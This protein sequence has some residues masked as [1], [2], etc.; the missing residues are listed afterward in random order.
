MALWQSQNRGFSI[1]EP[2][3]KLHALAGAPAG[4]LKPVP[5]LEKGECCVAL[6]KTFSALGGPRVLISI[7]A[8]SRTW[9]VIIVLGI[10][11]QWSI[12]QVLHQ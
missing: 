1:L 8:F 5:F 12:M 6:T 10:D 11:N 2:G 9:M 7:A 3:G 4:D